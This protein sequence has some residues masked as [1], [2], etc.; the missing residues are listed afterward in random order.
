MTTAENREPGLFAVLREPHAHLII[1][2]IISL[3]AACFLAAAGLFATMLLTVVVNGWWWRHNWALI[4]LSAASLAWL[5][6]LRLIWRPV[7]GRRQ[8]VRPIFS[9]VAIVACCAL[10]GAL[11]DHEPLIAVIVLLAISLTLYTWVSAYIRWSRGRSVFG[12][13]SVVD[14]HCPQ[15]RYS[16]VGLT[17]CR[18]PECGL[19]FTIDGLIAAQG[20]GGIYARGNERPA[21]TVE[22]AATD[23]AAGQVA[24]A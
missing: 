19:A 9:T 16:L 17:E 23:L 7:R 8:L 14:V 5:V 12:P 18:C 3:A 24:P 21:A 4:G 6:A 15:C 2:S 1:R 13:D 10:L 20:Y 22:G 11:L